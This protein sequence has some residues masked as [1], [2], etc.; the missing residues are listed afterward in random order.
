MM[1]NV[2][3]HLLQSQGLFQ[4]IPRGR[5]PKIVRLSLRVPVVRWSKPT[6]KC[7]S[8]IDD[9]KCCLAFVAFAG[10]LS[11]DPTRTSNPHSMA[12][13]LPRGSVQHW[14][15]RCPFRVDEALFVGGRVYSVIIICCSLCLSSLYVSSCPILEIVKLL[16]QSFGVS[17]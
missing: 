14:L 12:Q 7:K 11:E 5:E 3:W 16:K 2:A 9:G 13:K 10:S 1:A 6:N 4:K 15:H 17:K 8:R